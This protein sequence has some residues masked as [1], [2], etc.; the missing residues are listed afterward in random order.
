MLQYNIIVSQSLSDNIEVY[1]A[2]GDAVRLG[3]VRRLATSDKPVEGCQLVSACQQLS[4]LS[5]P[6]VS[7]HFARLV[8]C[9]VLLEEKRGAQKLYALNRGVLERA[10]ININQII[11]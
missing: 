10:G 5:Q 3:I 2:L 9:K 8:S 7:H 4:H 11:N 6:T 1:R